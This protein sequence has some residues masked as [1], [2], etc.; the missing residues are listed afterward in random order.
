[1]TATLVACVRRLLVI[2]LAG[3]SLVTWGSALPPALAQSAT[4]GQPPAPLPAT[5]IPVPEIAQRAEDVATFLRQS[6][7]R[8][9]TDPELEAVARQLPETSLWIRGRLIS[10]AQT[11]DSSPSSDALDNL[12]DLWTV[13][14]SE[15]TAWNDTV[16]RR[17]TQLERELNQ[18][19]AL[20]ASWSASRAAAPPSQVPAPV[21]ERITATLAAIVAAREAVERQRT[22]VLSLQDRVV[23]EIARCDAV[24]ARIA[25]ARNGLVGPL[26]AR[27]SEPIW[28]AQALAGI[29]SDAGQRLQ[30]SLADSTE[31]SRR[32]LAGQLARAPLQ[33]AVFGIVFVLANL[34]RRRARRLAEQAASEQAASEAA[35]AQVFEYPLA[36]AL[37]LALLATV[38]IY[39]LPPRVLI[40][41]VGLLILLP[42]VLIVRRLASPAVAPAVYA[43][44]AFFLV[45][46]VRELC[47]AV[48]V[49]EQ[50]LFLLEMVCGILFLALA[51]RSEHLA[52]IADGQGA[53]GWQHVL[54]WL[55][56]GQLAILTSA[57]FAGAFGYMRLA[58][59][60]G[61]AVLYSSYVALVLYAGVRV[62]DGLVA[63]VLRV[64]PLGTLFMVQH[65]RELLQRR[66]HLA[67]S[68]IAVGTW[69][70][71]TLDGLRVM[72]PT[73]TA[74]QD[75]LSA[76]YVRGSVNISLSDVVAFGLTI[77]ATF[78]LSSFLRFV[79][80]ED[81]YPRVGFPR[82]LP[83]AL[84]SLIHY[85]V[86]F[87]GF[88][89]AVAALG[90]D[91]N[92]ITILAGALGV[93]IGIGLQNVVA[94]F[95][96]GL[97]LLVERRIHV[98]DSI[99]TGDLEGEV[100][101]IGFRASTIRTGDGAD[102]IVPNGRLTSER[103]TNWTLT[104]RARR[105]TLKVGVAYASDPARVLDVL[106]AAAKTCPRVL[107]KPA[108]VALCTGFRDGALNF[109]LRVWTA[110]FEDS[111]LVLS[112]LAVAVRA[113]LA[114]AKIEIAFPLRDIHIRDAD[115]EPLDLRRREQSG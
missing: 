87:L 99:E 109:D 83:Y 8:R 7:E 80:H 45:D 113:A 65:H 10:T 49:L 104:D 42:A 19:G 33:V 46:H 3:V 37:V 82:G 78:L 15:L 5:P 98:G 63:Y 57:V 1:M 40:N 24:Q 88:I 74:V 112:D 67:L 23:R 12:S 61:T 76:R 27:D 81:V 2:A 9:A 21:L 77:W 92:R 59:L 11:L 86:I 44:A 108:V 85:T 97:I 96:S 53:L 62:G 71:L 56:W 36:S 94:N 47:A 55:L 111:D 95:V 25:G 107:D 102:V 100:R 39:P 52:T 34:A 31:L 54:T 41:G 73:V 29:S 90:F 68:W 4:S 84:S 38:W 75:L 93:G 17:A 60:L 79:L 110:S 35:A 13:M 22:Y 30:R 26:L 105:V 70:Y 32:Y 103:V 18:L 72:S 6:A 51:L 43:L 69:L 66:L 91:L 50:R 115:G 114:A 48:P 101:E 64:R 106:R 16:T 14:R 28:S 58:R 20:Q 89:F